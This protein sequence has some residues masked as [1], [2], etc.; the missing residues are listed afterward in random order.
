MKYAYINMVAGI[1]LIVCNSVNAQKQHPEISPSPRVI[2]VQDFGKMQVTLNYSRPSVKGRTIYAENG[3]VPFGKL[4]RTGASK[5]TTMAITA[6]IKI[7]S[8]TLRKG[9]YAILTVPGEKEWEIKFYDFQFNKWSKYNALPPT[10]SVRVKP[11]EQVN[12]TESLLITLENLRDSTAILQIVWENTLV[13][14]R[15]KTIVDQ[16]SNSIQPEK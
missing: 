8:K 3:L 13:P 15:L 5:V 11:V 9:K 2:M 10:L 7:E 1:L 16:P 6:P 12:F 4:W 14:L